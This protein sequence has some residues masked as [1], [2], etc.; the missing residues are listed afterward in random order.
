MEPAKKRPFL[1]TAVFTLIGR[2]GGLILPFIVAFFYGAGR[3]T[4]AFFFAY[5]LIFFFVAILTHL[6]ESVL[7]PY[8]VERKDEEGAAEGLAAG[9]FFLSRPVLG[10]TAMAALFLLGPLLSLGSG[11]DRES[12][13]LVSRFFFEMLPL[14]IF[15]AEIA[16][17]NGLFYTRRIFW[18]PAVSPLIR[19]AAVIVFVLILHRSL[20]AD[21]L[22]LG[23]SAGEVFRWAMTCLLF[24]SLFRLKSRIDWPKIMPALRHF[25]AQAGLQIISIAAVSIVPITNQWFASRLG[26][27]SLTLLNYADRLLQIPYILF[28]S[29]FLQVFLTDWS[30]NFCGNLPD[31]FHSRLRSD[32]RIVFSGAVLLGACLWFFREPLIQVCYGRSALTGDQLK[33]VSVIFGW[34]ALALIPGVMKLLYGR[35]LLV[36]RRAGL[37]CFQSC[38]ELVLN[39]VLTAVLIRFFVLAGIVMATASVYTVTAVWLHFAVKKCKAGEPVS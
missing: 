18:Y 28:I 29:G 31:S 6:Y 23:L 2:T 3:E 25:F 26:E 9:I 7:L 17:Q 16:S 11:W 4:D 13:R 36:F 8:L 20:G 22:T 5:S 38:V 27:G 34:L 1:S 24:R 37:Y 21:A 10:I 32:F 14:L 39:I 33:T 15:G 35:V 19:F 12:S 30:E